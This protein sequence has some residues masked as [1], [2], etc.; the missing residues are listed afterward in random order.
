MCSRICSAE[1]DEALYG[2]AGPAAPQPYPFADENINNDFDFV[3]YK[4]IDDSKDEQKEEELVFTSVKG[5]SEIVSTDNDDLITP[6]CTEVVPP[7]DVPKSKANGTW[8]VIEH[9]LPLWHHIQG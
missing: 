3:L 8:L 9:G 1:E 6:L 7:F 2:T 4:Q 5:C